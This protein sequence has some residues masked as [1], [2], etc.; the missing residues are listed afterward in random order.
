MHTCKHVLARTRAPRSHG[1]PGLGAQRSRLASARAA[2]TLR[3]GVSRQRPLRRTTKAGGGAAEPSRAL[4]MLL[5][6]GLPR[7]LLPALDGGPGPRSRV[8]REH[9]PEACPDED[10]TEEVVDAR[11]VN[12]IPLGP[13]LALYADGHDGKHAGGAGLED[14]VDADHR[15]LCV[16]QGPGEQAPSNEGAEEDLV[17]QRPEH[18]EGDLHEGMHAASRD[19]GT[20][21]RA[22]KPRQTWD[23]PRDKDKGEKEE[24]A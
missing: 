11:H 1:P 3:I 6:V 22:S 14:R 21:V 20:R 18:R 5:L 12:A 4:F 13:R 23:G 10:A 9:H 17:D 2:P 15:G 19:V 24:A 16:L 8:L 7:V